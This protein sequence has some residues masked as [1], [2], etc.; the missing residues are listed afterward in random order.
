MLAGEHDDRVDPMHA[1]KFVAA[2][3][4]WLRGGPRNNWS[5]GLLD[6]LRVRATLLIHT[7]P[8]KVQVIHTEV[9]SDTVVVI[10]TKKGSVR[11][12]LPGYEHCVR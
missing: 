2:I 4:I 5:F 3:Q 12:H 7:G 9:S 1:R 10:R 8:M 6:F 11:R